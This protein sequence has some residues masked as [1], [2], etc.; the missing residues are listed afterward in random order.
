M[1]TLRWTGVGKKGGK[2]REEKEQRP[3]KV[4][5]QTKK[6]V[7]AGTKKRKRGVYGGTKGGDWRPPTKTTWG[8]HVKG[9]KEQKGESR[10]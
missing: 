8:L 6:P 7:P 5:N 1:F 10:G 2:S 3:K 9:P 4:P